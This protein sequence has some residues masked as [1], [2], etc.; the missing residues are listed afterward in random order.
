MSIHEL[1]KGK[2][3]NGKKLLK[4]DALLLLYYKKNLRAQKV[5][6]R[7]ELLNQKTPITF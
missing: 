5:Y 1:Y 6:K 2:H 3:F 4:I 7:N